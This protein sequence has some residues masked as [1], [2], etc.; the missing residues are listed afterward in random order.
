MAD[1]HCRDSQMSVKIRLG[2]LRRVSKGVFTPAMTSKG[3]Y[4]QG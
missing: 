4:G 3:R 1:S 2:I